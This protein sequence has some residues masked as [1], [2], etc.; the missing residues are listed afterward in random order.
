MASTPKASSRMVGSP[1]STFATPLVEDTIEI[2]MV[3]LAAGQWVQL[4]FGTRFNDIE[5]GAFPKDLP[6]HV[7]VADEPAD[8][9]GLLR[10]RTWASNRTDQDRYNFNL[11]YDGNSV[12]HP[13][14]TRTYVF[15]REGYTP[16]EL[17]TPDPF[18]P[19]AFLVSEQMISETEP[20]SL[21]SVFVK[22]ARIY[23]TLPGPI[24]YSIE[25]PY[26]GLTSFPRITTKQKYAHM[27]FPD[28]LGNTCPVPNYQDAILV[29]QSIGQTDYFAIDQVQRIYDVVPR[30]VQIGEQLPD[31]SIATEVSYGGQEGFGYSVGYMYGRR[32]YPFIT[33]NLS[34]PKEDYLPAS[35]LSACPI[36]GY[37]SLKLVNQEAKADDKQTQ[38]LSVT[39]RFETL[40]GPLI[41]KVDYDNNNPLYPMVGTTQRVAITEYSPGVIGTDSCQVAGFTHLK[42]SEQHVAP[43]DFAVVKEDQRVFELNPG[44]MIVSGDYDSTVDAFVYTGRQK[45]A[46]GTIPMID[47]LTLEFREKPIDKYRSI[48][49]Q[50][51]LATLPATRVE[52]KTVNNWTF[53]TL[54]TGITLSKANLVASRAEVVWFPNTLRPVQNVPAILRLTT[55]YHT[56]PPPPATIFVTPTRNLIYQGISFQISIRNVLNDTIALSMTFASDTRYGNLSES[57]TFAATTPSATEYYSIIGQY[58]TVGCDISIW[59]GKIFVK[60]VTEVVLV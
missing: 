5:H 48:H 58:R 22:V 28:N 2:E 40:P 43:T 50:S 38:I 3:D 35:D 26:G 54:L 34:I 15:L 7:L 31:G 13:I 4:P 44:E 60:T 53:P 20:A 11:S 12:E 16:E 9:S 29:A 49:I 21:R 24:L 8:A 39:R 42:L 55:S 6:D 41:H 14:Y 32:E 27:K 52:F 23:Q 45:V 25:Y 46:L 30:I 17:L 47:D 18:D 57:V 1:I 56:S 51:Q 19:N 33:W 59:R 10:R 37:E 36:D